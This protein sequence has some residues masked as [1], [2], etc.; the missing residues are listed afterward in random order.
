[1]YYEKLLT[2]NLKSNSAKITFN[3]KGK[4][5]NI[6]SNIDLNII[7]N[8]VTSF[9]YDYKLYAQD[10]IIYKIS[11]TK[12]EIWIE[13]ENKEE[14]NISN[15]EY[16]INQCLI[17]FNREINNLPN[18]YMTK[19]RCI[20]KHN[21]NIY[22]R[23]TGTANAIKLII[24]ELYDG[25]WKKFIASYDSAGS[26]TINGKRLYKINTTTSPELKKDKPYEI[27]YNLSNDCFYLI[28]GSG[29][30]VLHSSG[31]A[32]PEHV[33]TGKTFSNN[34]GT[35]LAGTMSNL[36]QESTI[37]YATNNNAK[38]IKADAAFQNTNTDN[39]NRICLRYNNKNGY[40]TRN[41]LF[42]VPTTDV[43]NAMGLTPDKI[44]AGNTIGGITGTATAESLGGA[45]KF[46]QTV[47]VNEVKGQPDKYRIDVGFKPT[48]VLCW[49]LTTSIG[50]FVGHSQDLHLYSTNIT[51]LQNGAWIQGHGSSSSGYRPDCKITGLY[52]TG[53][54]Y[55]NGTKTNSKDSTF[56]MNV[57]AIG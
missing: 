54:Y 3:I 48:F 34:N 36:T 1:M 51:G 53:F 4:H 7:N 24:L 17:N 28:S 22:E 21:N 19:D 43:A 46:V 44:V 27:Y 11:N 50:G 15:L 26:V 25:Y 14:A 52:D 20:L 8:H 39:V 37:Q 33:L 9:S 47:T 55:G 16:D 49:V 6:N 35:N 32:L 38:V 57:I 56:K 40:I 42:G 2:I 13:L 29:S 23:A 31:N 45:K 30:T 12:F 10:L 41:T 5:S 18:E